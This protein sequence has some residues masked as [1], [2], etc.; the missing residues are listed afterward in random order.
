MQPLLSA[1]QWTPSKSVQSF[2]ALNPNTGADTGEEYPISDWADLQ[3]MA[4]AA[5]AA[6][7]Q[8]RDWPGERF[9]AFLDA[10]ADNV[11]ANADVIATAAQEE[12]G[13]GY[14]PRLRVGEMNRTIGQL[15]QAAD[16]AR[17]S[18]WRLPTIDTAAGVRSMHVGIGPVFVIG[19]NNFP[20]A[21]N[22]ISG[23]DF[24][25]A[26]AAG[27]PVI[28]KSH[29]SHPHTSQLLA[30]AMHAAAEATD[31]PAG[32]VQMFYHCL[33]ETGMQLLKSPAITAVAFTGSRAAGM[34]LKETADKLGKPAF[35]EMSSL[36]P[37]VLLDGAL[38]SRGGEIA[39]QFTGSCL[40]GG[41]QF[42]TNPGLVVLPKGE[43]A[44]AFISDVSARFAA[45]P[46]PTMLGTGGRDHF[47]KSLGVLRD[48][49]ASQIAQAQAADDERV[50]VQPTLLTVDGGTFVKH[51]GLLQTEVFGP[52]SLF[53]IADD[54][55]QM[56]EV[57]DHLEGNLTGCFYADASDQAA[58]D[59]LEPTLRRKVGRLLNDQMPTGV[60]VS[61]AMNH[62]GPYPATGHPGFSAVGLPGAAR[63]FAILASYDNVA[64]NRLP[65]P[66]RNQNP[67]GVWRMV[68][69]A[70]TTDDVA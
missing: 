63:R 46:C 29:P 48:T 64:D 34:A 15:R 20:L 23:G 14:E 70:W 37:V 22:A 11:E 54:L 51:S 5:R 13:L 19:P 28:A 68:D 41:G 25:A 24:A 6:F 8:V 1:G 58:Y 33:P 31:M 60:A 45:A 39:E 57:L 26:I 52:S 36:N 67:G 62:G 40:M 47:E 27:C 55:A 9:A 35:L 61:A 10:A 21:F 49:G 30:E 50:S 17:T 65:A 7:E 43:A 56:A 44:D 4:D 59:R 18:S 53:V 32:F 38:Q 12:T 16:A 2:R 66:L 42:C 69:G 3:P